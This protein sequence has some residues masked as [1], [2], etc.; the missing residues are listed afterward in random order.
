MQAAFGDETAPLDNP[1]E[2]VID[3]FVDEIFE[4]GDGEY[5]LEFDGLEEA[6]AKAV[7]Y[8]HLAGG[9]YSPVWGTAASARSKERGLL[10]DCC[11]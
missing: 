9:F 11:R 8:T 2:S 7:S 10:R 5:T 6:A 3:G 1:L 4:A